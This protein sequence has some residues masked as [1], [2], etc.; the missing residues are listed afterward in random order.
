MGKVKGSTNLPGGS[1]PGPKPGSSSKKNDFKHGLRQ[2]QLNFLTS[3]SSNMTS[4][5]DIE[6]NDGPY[7]VDPNEL[8]SALH[9]L[10]GVTTKANLEAK[11]DRGRKQRFYKAMQGTEID[12]NH[13]QDNSEDIVQEEDEIDELK[14]S[15]RE[16][17]LKTVQ[18]SLKTQFDRNKQIDCYREKQFI[19]RAPASYFEINTHPM[20]PLSP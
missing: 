10:S 11:P 7:A 3:P 4:P 19:I 14:A 13:T 1:K 12:I 16:T 20:E 2:A 15:A 9:N 6:M 17:Y 8:A 18:D 5:I